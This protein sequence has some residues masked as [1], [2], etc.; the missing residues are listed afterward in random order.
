[1]L[2]I[3]T[4]LFVNRRTSGPIVKRIDNYGPPNAKSPFGH[5]DDK[6]DSKSEVSTD[7]KVIKKH[8][9]QSADENASHADASGKFRV[10]SMYLSDSKIEVRV[11]NF[12]FNSLDPKAVKVDDKKAPLT[13]PSFSG[14]PSAAQR[15]DST[16][17]KVE[18][19]SI[20][21]SE[22]TSKVASAIA[23]QA[24]QPQRSE[25]TPPFAASE[26]SQHR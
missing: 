13:K 22:D 14:P 3:L 12:S 18:S 20:S 23:S 19:Q 16:G 4:L 24:P 8:E 11:I 1:M 9:S 21:K 6:S 17:Q 15:K 5:S 10:S 25:K 2:N 26:K 7:E